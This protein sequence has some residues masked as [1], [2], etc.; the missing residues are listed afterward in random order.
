MICVYCGG[1]TGDEY[2]EHDDCREASIE[3]E[4]EECPKPLAKCAATDHRRL[5]KWERGRITRRRR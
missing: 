4:L 5:D 1:E 2:D 3:E